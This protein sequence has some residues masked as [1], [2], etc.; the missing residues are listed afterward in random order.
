MVKL[1]NKLP[2]KVDDKTYLPEDIHQKFI[3]YMQN[4][5]MKRQVSVP[6]KT[7]LVQQEDALGCAIAALAMAVGCTYAEMRDEVSKYWMIFKPMHDYKGLD[8]DDE[9][10]LLYRYGIR[11]LTMKAHAKGPEL[12]EFIGT[13]P[14]LL[15]VKSKNRPGCGHAVYWN[16]ENVYDP[17]KLKT[18][19]DADVWNA[20]YA[21]TMLTPLPEEAP[22]WALF[23]I[24]DESQNDA[25]Y[26]GPTGCPSPVEQT[27][28]DLSPDPL[29]RRDGAGGRA[30]AGKPQKT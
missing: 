19:T 1:K 27:G 15:S 6:P 23:G 9:R 17:S 12:K 21:Y 14:T 20:V 4:E 13:T 18:Y 25:P 28:Q 11:P 7:V 22:D 30:R 3:G 26:P 10:I 2:V 24:N 5:R 16:G 29:G 8:G